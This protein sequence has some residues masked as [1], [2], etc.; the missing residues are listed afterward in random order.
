[1]PAR[2]ARAAGL[3]ERRITAFD[4]ACSSYLYEAMTDYAGSLD[5]LR[6][7]IGPEAALDLS[8]EK[9]RTAL[10]RFLNAWG[11]RNL[12]TDWHP[13]ASGELKTWFLGAQEWLSALDGPPWT[14]DEVG[15][16]RLP[17]VFDGLSQSIAAHTV[18]KGQQLCVSFG[19]TATSKTLFILRPDLFT[20]WD[21]AMRGV[22]G[23][24]G[25]GASYAQFTADVHAKIAESVRTCS[26][27]RALLEA[28]PK[29]LNRPDYTTLPQMVGEYYWITLT[30]RVKLRSREQVAEWLS[31]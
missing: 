11:C 7:G 18:R 30:R 10:L 2:R 31:W 25:D 20:A 4:L 8:E 22:C 17:E 23:Y 6:Q 9:Q 1:M 29:A 13:L 16:R 28:L 26:G 12:A 5:Q 3:P 19:P 15:R 27:G 21:G 24:A 14:S